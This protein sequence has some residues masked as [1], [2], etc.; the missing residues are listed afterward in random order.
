M[1]KA[2]I[3]RFFY[4]IQGVKDSRGRG[5]KGGR[6]Y[7]K[8]LGNLGILAQFRHFIRTDEVYRKITPW[9]LESLDLFS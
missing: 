8:N 1:L 7:S 9:N 3:Q 5:F 2:R 4:R 6:V